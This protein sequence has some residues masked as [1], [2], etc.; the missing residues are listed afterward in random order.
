MRPGSV[1]CSVWVA[2][3]H[4]RPSKYRRDPDPAGSG[5]HPAVSGACSIRCTVSASESSPSAG[6]FEKGSSI[7]NNGA[8]KA[9]ISERPPRYARASLS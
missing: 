2:E 8:D 7:N 9:G 3:V 1:T 5:Y 6:G 4:E